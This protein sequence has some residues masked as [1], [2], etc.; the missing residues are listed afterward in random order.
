MIRPVLND[1][2]Q[3]DLFVGHR[4]KCSNNF[5]VTKDDAEQK[6]WGGKFVFLREFQEAD[7]MRFHTTVTVLN[8]P[9]KRLAFTWSTNL[10]SAITTSTICSPAT[11][12]DQTTTASMTA[13]LLFIKTDSYKVKTGHGNMKSTEILMILAQQERFCTVN[14]GFLMRT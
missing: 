8:D 9:C 5:S 12:R 6:I 13:I 2:R 10:Q 4:Q 14:T 11:S 7:E 3:Y 1:S